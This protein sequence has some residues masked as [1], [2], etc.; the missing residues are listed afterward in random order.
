MSRGLQLA[1]RGMRMKTGNA[2]LAGL[3]MAMGLIMGQY[4]LQAIKPERAKQV[5]ICQ[6]CSV[7]NP[8]ENKFCRNCGQSL[9]P[10]PQTMCPKCKA[11]IPSSMEFCGNCGS[12]LKKNVSSIDRTFMTCTILRSICVSTD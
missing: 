2:F 4:M 10:P 3:G 9:C 12:P 11:K 5:I 6:R 1:E 7:M 8:V